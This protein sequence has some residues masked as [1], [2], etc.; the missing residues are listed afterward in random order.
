MSLVLHETVCERLTIVV[1][2]HAFSLSLS[3]LF[4]DEERHLKAVVEKAKMI[5]KLSHTKKRERR[6][7]NPTQTLIGRTIQYGY[8]I[9]NF[10]GVKTAGNGWF[11]WICSSS[12]SFHWTPPELI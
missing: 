7:H 12:N 1:R 3:L 9:P 8:Y 4:E 11:G 10:P 6:T 2:L 5:A